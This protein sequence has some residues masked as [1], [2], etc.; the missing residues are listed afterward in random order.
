MRE[1]AQ[2][3]RVSSKIQLMKIV[4]NYEPS[5]I[6]TH[7]ICV[8]HNALPIELVGYKITNMIIISYFTNYC[9]S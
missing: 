8:F 5:G 2:S 7:I 3:L 6:W 1:N 4:H 9:N